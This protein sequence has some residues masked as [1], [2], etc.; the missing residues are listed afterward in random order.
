MRIG[1]NPHRRKLRETVSGVQRSRAQSSLVVRCGWGRGRLAAKGCRLHF[2]GRMQTMPKISRRQANKLSAILFAKSRRVLFVQKYG[3]CRLCRGCRAEPLGGRF[4]T[5]PT[6][7]NVMLSRRPVA[8]MGARHA[9]PR[10][11]HQSV[12][13]SSRAPAALLRTARRRPRVELGFGQVAPRHVFRS[14]AHRLRQRR[15]D[16]NGMVKPVAQTIVDLVIGKIAP[17]HNRRS[18]LRGSRRLCR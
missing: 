10:C 4:A 9:S 2:N 5:P 6:A 8:L 14:P 16:A 18:R 3:L 13:S 15:K 7:E 1:R 17:S 12:P 11:A